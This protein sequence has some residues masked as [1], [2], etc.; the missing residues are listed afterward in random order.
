MEFIPE[1]LRRHID[2]EVQ[3]PCWIWKGA[4]DHYGTARI[5]KKIYG[6]GM[7]R[8]FIYT[9]A[10]GQHKDKGELKSTCRRKD[11]VNPGHLTYD[12]TPLMLQEDFFAQVEKTE[13]CWL[14]KGCVCSR[15]YGY[16]NAEKF[17]H[18][19]AHRY[20]FYTANPT[21][22]KNVELRHSCVN[23]NC[24]NP[25]HLTTG[26]PGE[27][28]KANMYDALANG[29]LNNQKLNKQTALAIRQKIL[30]GA[31]TKDLVKEL[32]CSK[33]CIADLKMGRTWNL[34]E[35]FPPGWK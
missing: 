13:G 25:L 30:D 8:Q 33:V 32:G 23:H 10:G 15:G 22:V 21:A 9:L 12:W 20:S 27:W 34:P 2:L 18:S 5:N 6:S 31:R 26:I 24:V 4:K 17:G 1:P 14:W 7:A 11:C 19:I 16:L 29:S 35:C 28:N 3:R